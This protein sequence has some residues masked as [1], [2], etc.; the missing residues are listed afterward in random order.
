MGKNVIS[1]LQNENRV[2]IRCTDNST[3]HGNILVGANG[4][5][6]AVRQKLHAHIKDKGKLP[7]S[8]DLVLV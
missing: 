8:D 5:Y 3:H 7:K 6:S 1:L 4:A 2:M